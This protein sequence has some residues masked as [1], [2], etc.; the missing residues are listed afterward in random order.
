LFAP[1]ARAKRE[2][3]DERKDAGAAPDKSSKGK[4]KRNDEKDDQDDGEARE[5]RS[6]E[7]DNGLQIKEHAVG[8]GRLPEQWELVTVRYKAEVEHGNRLGGGMLS[9]KL[10]SGHMVQ[11]FDQAVMLMKPGGHATVTVP[12]DLAYGVKAPPTHS[13]L[14]RRE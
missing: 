6:Y 8:H 12:A 4:R 13:F 11:G 9:F 7:L 5:P 1:I 14:R 2:A 3:A 10:G